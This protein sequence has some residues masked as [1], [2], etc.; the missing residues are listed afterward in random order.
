[1]PALQVKEFPADLYDDLRSCAAEQD[2]SISQQTVHILREYLRAY[3]Q[4]AGRV[5]WVARAVESDAPGRLAFPTE[6][7]ADDER[8]GRIERRKRLF[9]RIDAAP[10]F[11]VPDDFPSPAELIRADRGERDARIALAVDGKDLR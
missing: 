11:S 5:D 6:H 9:E 3:R 10:R 1:M 4:A 7:T 2:R 8:R